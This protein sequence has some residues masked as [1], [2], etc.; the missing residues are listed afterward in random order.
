M[1]NTIIL[2]VFN[3]EHLLLAN[4][5]H[6]LSRND[7]RDSEVLIV[8]DG[9]TKDYGNL[10]S[11]SPPY[12]RWIR[13]DTVRDR[14]DT[15]HIDGHNNP[16]YANNVAV[17]E[18]KGRNLF[19]LSS[20]VLIPPH[21]M[22]MAMKWDLSRYVWVPRVVNLRDAAI[23]LGPTRFLPACWFLATTKENV[24]KCG[25][26][27]EEYLKGMAFED[28]DFGA[29]ILLETGKM[30]CDWA[31]TVWHQPHEPVAYSDDWHGF[32]MS[33]RYTKQKWGGVP[34]GEEDPLK[35]QFRAVGPHHQ[36]VEATRR[37]VGVH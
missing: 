10:K 29:R 17:A 21:T 9:S 15:Y 5:L 25:G 33:E 8:D 30:V 4:T 7:L 14:P 16:A 31:V 37:E 12:V 19:F 27:D 35:Y 11:G 20:D 23:F 34:F 3:R 2:T 22:T 1:K 18:A 36:L 26:F 24:L 32:K 6:W 28:N 13:V